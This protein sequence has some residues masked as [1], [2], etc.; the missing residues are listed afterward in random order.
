MASADAVAALRKS[1]DA[2]NRYRLD[3]SSTIDLRLAQLK[4]QNLRERVFANCDL[5]G[6]ELAGSNLDLCTFEGAHL[7]DTSF[8]N[9][10][11]V[12]CE[13]AQLDTYGITF[14]YAIIRESRFSDSSF[15]NT[16]FRS[17]QISQTKLSECA[18]HGADIDHFQLNACD[19]L[20][21]TISAASGTGIS[22]SDCRV[23][24][25][26]IRD[27]K[28]LEVRIDRFNM[29]DSEFRNAD[30]FGGVISESQ[31]RNTNMSVV[32]FRSIRFDD[33]DF[34]G[35]TIR[36][37][38]LTEYDLPHAI[39]LGTSIV[40]CK[41]PRQRPTI[42]LLGAHRRSASLVSQPVQDL[43]GLSAS[44]RREIA[45]AQ[46]LDEL[47]NRTASRL[48]SRILFRIW[49]ISSAYGQSLIRLSGITVLMIFIL[50][51]LL[52]ISDGR[53]SAWP[54]CLSAIV[55]AISRMVN[56]F[57]GFGDPSFKNERALQRAV[58]EFA[59]FLGF[60]DLGLWIGI[61]AN[62]LGRLSAE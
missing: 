7:G 3:A 38:D 31:I 57:F 2:W 22:F 16:T 59:R 25:V 13:F 49:G 6:A 51:G 20:N 34:T 40:G 26:S 62:R 45:D 58:L 5:T 21:G 29:S 47:A 52:V 44:L 11:L 30:I 61:A 1:N 33:I 42:S 46:Y 8:R 37:T 54:H 56:A 4:N 12:G 41:W 55:P 28:W 27:C 53:V 18:F 60:I 43:R 36:Y 50:S 48:T 35:S 15:R 19:F 14:D 10:S 23:S 39:M 9:A 24:H 17:T 32:A